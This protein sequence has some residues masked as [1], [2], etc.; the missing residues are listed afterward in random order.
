MKFF[1]LS[2]LHIGLKLYNRDLSEDQKYIF[3]QITD[4][5]KKEKPDAVLIAG[6]IYDKAIPSAESVSIFDEFVLEL[7]REVPD[8]VIMMISGN[9]DS[10]PRVNIYRDILKEQQIYMVGLPPQ[11]PEEWIQKVTL[12]DQWGKVNFY[13]LPFVKPSMVKQIVG[14]EDNGILLSYQDTVKRLLERESIQ[15]KE[16]NV[17]VS[18]QFYLPS[19]EK[20]EE[21]E[22][23]DSEIR[24]VGNIDQISADIL[25][26]FDYC[27]L[28]HIHKPMKAGSDK[29][30]YCGTP[31]AT[32]VSEAG[33]KK[34][35]LCVELKE[36]GRCDITALPL[37]PLHEVTVIKG[38]LE[39]VLKKA[40]EDYVSVVLTDE[41]D[42]DVLDMQDRL[43]AAFP[44][45]LEIRRET[46]RKTDYEKAEV[47]MKADTDPYDLCCAFLKDLEEAEKELLQEVINEVKEEQS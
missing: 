41:V 16:R 25:E 23:M 9:H 7:K 47:Q 26:V 2:D 24:T 10:A 28:G 30:R 44:N 46:A 1:H 33:Q 6:D 36:K 13:L 35:V 42:L 37:H 4:L 11:R 17:L 29:I 45:L 20:A 18:H 15:K 34:A 40:C 19:G 14:T 39:E 31:L 27:A 43:Y 12:E 8:A 32:S 3:R 38:G 21:I 5:A 22:R